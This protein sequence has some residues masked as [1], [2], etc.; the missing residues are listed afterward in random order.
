MRRRCRRQHVPANALEVDD[1]DTGATMPTPVTGASTLDRAPAV[2]QVVDRFG[3][4]VDDSSI[5]QQVV[6]ERRLGLGDRVPQRRVAV[7]VALQH[8]AQ[9]RDAAGSSAK[10]HVQQREPGGLARPSS[11]AR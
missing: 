6:A 11:R 5:G 1:V 2:G 7:A 8:R 4:Q 3:Q 10:P 9:R